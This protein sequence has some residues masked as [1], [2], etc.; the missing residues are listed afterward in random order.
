[1]KTT[2]RKNILVTSMLI[3]I[4]DDP[5]IAGLAIDIQERL[6]RELKDILGDNNY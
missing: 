4:D 1:M 3:W 2:M 6:L 5:M